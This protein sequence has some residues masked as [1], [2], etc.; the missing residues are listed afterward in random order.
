MRKIFQPS[1]IPAEIY[2]SSCIHISF[3]INVPYPNNSYPSED[4]QGPPGERAPQFGNLWPSA[5]DMNSADNETW[6]MLS[7]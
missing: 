1:K 7:A 2:I 6:L 3:K 4:Q 5:E